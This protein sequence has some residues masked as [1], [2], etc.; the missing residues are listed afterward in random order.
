[1]NCHVR[2][3][4]YLDLGEYCAYGAASF[5]ERVHRVTSRYA[6]MQKIPYILMSVIEHSGNAFGGHYQT[7]RRVDQEQSDWV[8]VS[9]ESVVSR[10]WTE[11]RKCQAY[12][13]FYVVV[14]P[15]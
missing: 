3:D 12:M 14:S 5:E 7:Y 2:F 8:L 10:T 9:D 4:E 15:S 1:M 11:V 13:L 6:Q